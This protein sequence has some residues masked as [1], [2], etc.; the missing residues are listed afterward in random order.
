M[1][2]PRIDR[3]A[4]Q[5]WIIVILEAM[6]CGVPIVTTPTA[7]PLEIIDDTTACFAASD[8][9]EALLPALAR[10]LADYDA[11]CARAQAAL[12]RFRTNY[13]PDVVV[14]RYLELYAELIADQA[15]RRQA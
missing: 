6:A 2:A 3:V 8:N 15:R 13:T 7:G 5:P 14:A 10:T 9:A 4:A 1:R 11:A 12:D